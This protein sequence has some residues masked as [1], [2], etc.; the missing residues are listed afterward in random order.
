MC[1]KKITIRPF[2]PIHICVLHFIDNFYVLCLMFFANILQIYDDVSLLYFCTL[3]YITFLP[4]GCKLT[5][6]IPC[7]QVA[8]AG[9]FQ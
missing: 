6:K 8:S 5:D 7:V 3:Y 1:S 2:F 9:A 4:Y